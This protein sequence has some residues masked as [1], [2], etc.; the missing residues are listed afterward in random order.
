MGGSLSKCSSLNKAAGVTASTST[1]AELRTPAHCWNGPAP[2]PAPEVG[3][4]ARRPSGTIT[5]QDHQNRAG[6]MMTQ[7]PRPRC[8]VVQGVTRGVSGAGRKAKQAPQKEAETTEKARHDTICCQAPAPQVSLRKG[9]HHST[10]MRSEAASEAR[11]FRGSQAHLWSFRSDS[12]RATE[13][14]SPPTQPHVLEGTQEDLGRGQGGPAD[15]PPAPGEA[16]HPP[17]QGSAAPRMTR[18][19]RAPSRA[20]VRRFLDGAS[21]IAL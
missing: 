11:W 4:G 12:I 1:P 18:G 3:R 7:A 8:S 5:H 20:A 2:L 13:G 21:R 19:L 10:G 6:L 9:Q 16:L 15:Q 17:S 14:V